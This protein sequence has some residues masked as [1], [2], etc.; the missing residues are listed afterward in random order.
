MLLKG[1]NI[2]IRALSPRNLL[3]GSLGFAVVDALSTE[4][5]KVPPCFF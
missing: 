4:I 2:S 1:I 5:P 3:A